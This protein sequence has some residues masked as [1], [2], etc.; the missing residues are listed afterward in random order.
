MWGIFVPELGIFSFISMHHLIPKCLLDFLEHTVLISRTAGCLWRP[1]SLPTAVPALASE[2]AK[3][4]CSLIAPL[5]FC[6]SVSI[7][8]LCPDYTGSQYPSALHLRK[9]CLL[10]TQR[11]SFLVEDHMLRCFDRQ[12]SPNIY[13]MNTISVSNKYPHSAQSS[14]FWKCWASCWLKIRLYPYAQIYLLFWA[15]AKNILGD[16][17]MLGTDV[18]VGFIKYVVFLV[19]LPSN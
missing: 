13:A 18:I 9:R 17:L 19:V 6:H 16:F 10:S 12:I 7:Q 3:I 1:V 2:F 8:F 4:P 14:N 11:K 5:V 15:L